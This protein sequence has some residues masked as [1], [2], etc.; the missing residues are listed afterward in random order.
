MSGGT[1]LLLPA[2]QP[3]VS[4]LPDGGSGSLCLPRPATI[5]LS[6]A[7]AA[8]GGSPHTQRLL[9]YPARQPRR[10][11]PRVSF[12]KHE[13]RGRSPICYVG[14]VITTPIPDSAAPSLATSRQT[15]RG[16]GSSLTYPPFLC[17]AGWYSHSLPAWQPRA[18]C[19][20]DSGSGSHYLALS[21]FCAD[22]R[23][24]WL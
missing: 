21:C 10:G 13:A 23:P 6:L 24:H 9:P 12:P 7:F 15:D 8:P 2:R 5:C 22:F 4:C 1:D 3:R 14:R 20:P 17:R 19:L 16:S 18:R 11:K